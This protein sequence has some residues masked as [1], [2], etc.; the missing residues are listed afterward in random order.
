MYLAIT[1]VITGS[2]YL[3]WQGYLPIDR[4]VLYSGLFSMIV[5]SVS[6]LL[7]LMPQIAKGFE[8]IRSL[9]EVIECPDIEHNQ[10]RENVTQA[11][12]AFSF[13][14]IAYQYNPNAPAALQNFTLHVQPGECIAFVGESG[15]GKST[16][17]QLAIGFLRPT[18]GRIMID[19]RNMEDLD[20]RS[21]RR[22]A[23]V[24]PQQTLLFS[25]TIRDNITYG[26]SSY[27]ED[28]VQEAIQAANL[29]AVI[30]RFTRRL[31]HPH[32]RERCKII[33]RPTPAHCYC[34]ALLFDES[35]RHYSRR[36]DQRARC[37]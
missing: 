8:A 2:T 10:D 16:L 23:A 4:I 22:F 18:A 21:W 33:R 15:S 34:T 17:M 26:L 20:M 30:D 3:V 32:R 36:S 24:V 12:G 35:H 25:G 9:G 29:S 11:N 37:Y 5:H 7:N 27:N 28:Q 13:E 31:R 14:D 19:G 6:A 1:V